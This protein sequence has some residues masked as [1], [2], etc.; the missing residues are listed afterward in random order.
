MR[1]FVSWV[2]GSAFSALMI[3]VA[4]VVQPYDWLSGRHILIPW[5]SRIWARALLRLIGAKL[6]VRGLEHV[7]LGHGAFLVSNHQSTIDIVAI[8][9]HTP[10]K[11]VFVSK[12]ENFLIPFIGWHL[13]AAGHVSL[14][15]QNRRAALRGMDK[16]RRAV[17]RGWRVA[18]FPEGTR[19]RDGTVHSFKKGAFAAAI[20]DQIPIVP[21][22]VDGAQHVMAKNGWLIRPATIR[23]CYGPPISTTGLTHGDRVAL[24]ERVRETIVA[25]HR[26]IGGA[27]AAPDAPHVAGAEAR[28]A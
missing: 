6:E 5:L 15:R 16:A 17:A 20:E 13:W 10:G 18:I 26:S 22:A 4:L 1:S 25:M 8:L 7:P 3:T 24:L 12:K 23:V 2:L 14:D 9:A 28:V 19:S 21:M 11:T 27:G